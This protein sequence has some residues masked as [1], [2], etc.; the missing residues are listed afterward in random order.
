MQELPPPD[1]PARPKPCGY[2]A[3]DDQPLFDIHLWVPLPFNML[4]PFFTRKLVAVGADAASTDVSLILSTLSAQQTENA[5]FLPDLRAHSLG[6]G[7][8]V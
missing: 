7:A 8:Q 6:N 1:P 2:G 5:V 4:Y 3:I